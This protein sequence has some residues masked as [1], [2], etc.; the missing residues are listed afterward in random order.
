[1]NPA[2]LRE[3]DPQAL[4]DCAD[5]HDRLG[6]E[7]HGGAQDWRTG[8]RDRAGDPGWL[9]TAAD[10][11]RASLRDSQDR[12]TA[13]EDGLRRLGALL[14]SG[15]EAVQLARARLVEA[16]D[17]AAA[18]G[19]TV[20]P[21]GRLTRPAGERHDPDLA[22]TELEQRIDSALAQADTADRTL[23]EHLQAHTRA[24]RDGSALATG[25]YSPVPALTAPDLLAAA[26]PPANATPAE[27]AAWWRTLPP[28]TQQHLTTTRPDLIGNRDGLP[29][30]TRDQANRLLLTAHL[31]DYAGRTS[32]TPADR[33]R[34]T[35]FR[36]IQTRLTHS[37]ATPPVLLLALSDQGQGRAALSFGNPDTATNVSAYVPGLGTELKDVGGKDADRAFNVWKAAN[38]ADPTRSAASI[39]WLGY[40][41]PPGLDKA[42]PASLSVM[43]DGRARAGAANYSRFLAGLRAG[44]SDGPAHLTALGHSYGSL[45]VGLSGQTPTGSGADDMILVGSP[46]TD[47][48]DASRLGVAPGHV[49]VGAADNDPV[50]YLPD[51]VAD[52]TGHSDER[53]FGR[54]PA[55][56]GF[57]AK[58]FE[59]ADGPPHSF[60]SHSN[61]LDPSG[62]SSLTNIGQIVAGHPDKVKGQSFR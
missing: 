46:G 36:A 62:G 2:A 23:A 41:P 59:V 8:V 6:G 34:L 17:E 25:G 30:T 33:T 4:P 45:T 26:L 20:T 22:A 12:L 3:A 11:C 13:A 16:L 15:A 29:A 39:V 38:K 14:R 40:D 7:L 56:A 19:L 1:M 37:P 42:D 47:S 61:Y 9:G 43:G 28:A 18:A 50:T 52:L 27:V 24:A 35:G 54:D 48:D 55:S 60:S 57:G 44:H 51:P 49:W 31:A 5:A 21:E 32:P 53:W 58:R 10:N